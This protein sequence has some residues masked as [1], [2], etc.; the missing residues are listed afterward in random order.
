MCITRKFH[1]ILAAVIV[2]YLVQVPRASCQSANASVIAQATQLELIFK[3][4]HRTN[5]DKEKRKLNDSLVKVVEA[6]LKDPAS[7]NQ[8][9]DSIKYLGKV[10]SPD[11]TFRILNWDLSFNDNTF[12]YFT[13]IQMNPQGKGGYRVFP[14]KDNPLVR[15]EIEQAQYT[16]E[17]WYGALIY[18][19]VHTR[20]H[21]QDFYTLLAM[22]FNDLLS[23]YKLID[24]LTFSKNGDPVF[25]APVFKTPEG[26]KSR[27]I[28]EYAAQAS[29]GLRWDEKVSMIVFDH[30]SPIRPDMTGN[31]KFYG[32]DFSYDGLKFEKGFWIFKS[33][34]DLT[35]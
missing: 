22:E 33:D 23:S 3:Q 32:P 35:N 12:A 2:F 30:L 5:D 31:F 1:G 16:S 29:M 9:L 6:F 26:I 19:V 27:M 24:I 28:F 7:Y 17:N 14:V 11:N 8:S 13:Y 4:L 20:Y 34:L 15:S 25:G 21:K 10:P 18:K